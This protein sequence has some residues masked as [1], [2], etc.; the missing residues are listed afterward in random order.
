M[1][2]A[3]AVSSAAAVVLLVAMA[4]PVEVVVAIAVL[5]VPSNLVLLREVA[6]PMTVQG[7]T[8]P[9]TSKWPHQ[10]SVIDLTDLSEIALIDWRVCGVF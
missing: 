9:S 5:M 8:D 2:V 7:P 1:A 4:V 3:A 10:W 6:R